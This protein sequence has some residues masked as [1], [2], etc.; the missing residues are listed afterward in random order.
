M[1]ATE[2]NEPMNDDDFKALVMSEGVVPDAVETVHLRYDALGDPGIS[3]REFV[4]GQKESSPHWWPNTYEKDLIDPA[5]KEAACGAKP[6]LDA[7]AALRKA[8]GPALYAEI[9]SDWGVSDKFLGPDG[10][11]APGKN[12]KTASQ[13]AEPKKT[14]PRD[15]SNNPFHKSQW[16]ISKQGELVKR[17]GLA[18]TNAIAHSVGSHVGATRPNADY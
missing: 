4:R 15:H 14:T 9:L 3:V 16:N 6:T 12:P 8:A 17:L 18:K 7:R 5:L 10:K 13:G 2:G 11:L 1:D